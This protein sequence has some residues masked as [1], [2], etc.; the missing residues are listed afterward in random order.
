MVS[1]RIATL[2]AAEAPE[3]VYDK[4]EQPRPVRGGDVAVL[5]RKFTNLDKLLPK[6]RSDLPQLS[7]QLFKHLRQQRLRP[8]AL[9]LAWAVMHFDD[10]AVRSGRGRRQGHRGHEVP[11]A[12][13][14]AGIDKDGQMT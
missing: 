1:R 2:L 14:M 5:F 8:V 10:D 13:S 7:H 11:G 3:R 4:D 12:S 6:H 9:R